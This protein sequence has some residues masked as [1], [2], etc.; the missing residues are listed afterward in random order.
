MRR[1][2]F[3]T[4]LGSA[5]VTASPRAQQPAI[6]VIGYLSGATFEMMHDYVAAFHRS[7]ADEGFAEDRNVRIEYRWAE[8]HIWAFDD[9]QAI[10][11]GY[12]GDADLWRLCNNAVYSTL[13]D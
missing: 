5:A 1:R 7:L 9:N 12:C 3:I 4:L 8:G 11:V 13:S 2:E 10:S 6:P